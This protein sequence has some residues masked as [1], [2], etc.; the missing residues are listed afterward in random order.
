MKSRN[1]LSVIFAVASAVLAGAPKAMAKSDISP[2]ASSVAAQILVRQVVDHQNILLVGTDAS[3]GPII[4]KA[5]LDLNGPTST[6]Y[7]LKSISCKSVANLQDSC[8]IGFAALNDD[9]GFSQ[10]FDLEVLTNLNRPD[11]GPQAAEAH[12]VK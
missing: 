1:T 7:A 2:E 8:V 6:T 10:S 3:F 12:I 9:E 5:L 4:E 11:V